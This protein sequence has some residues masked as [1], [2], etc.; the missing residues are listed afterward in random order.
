MFGWSYC[1]LGIYQYFE[2]SLKCLAQGHY[3][4]VVG[5]EPW[6]SPS[7]VQRSTTEPPRPLFHELKAFFFISETGKTLSYF[8]IVI[9]TRWLLFKIHSRLNAK[10]YHFIFPTK[11]IPSTIKVIFVQAVAISVDRTKASSW[12]RNV[13][14]T[15][16]KDT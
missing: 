5:L 3:M 8:Q 10:L 2:K 13:A 6:T 16:L 12:C 1:L 14:S 7:G 4:T 15:A 9:A 11:Y